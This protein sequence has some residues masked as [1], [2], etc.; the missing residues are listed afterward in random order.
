MFDKILVPLDG[1]TVAESAL[2]YARLLAEKSGCKVELLQVIDSADEDAWARAGKPIQNTGEEA[3]RLAERYLAE[4]AESF[5]GRRAE[6]RARPGSPAEVI[7]ETAAQ[8]PNTLIVLA[9]HGRTG[10]DRWLLGSVAEKV[11]RASSNPL[12]LV[13]ASK[14]N[15]ADEK[16][17]L[18]AILVPLDGSKLA[19]LALPPAVELARVLQAEV[20]LVGAYE[21]PS[22]AYYRSD[23]E[24]ATAA[25]F[26]PSYDDLVAA[27]S[28]ETRVYL[29]A[30]VQEL[31]SRTARV[32]SEIL[33]GP[34]AD[35]I[36]E[37]AHTTKGSLIAM[38]THG[39]S[40][41]RRW[42]LGSVTEKVARHADAPVLI[43]GAR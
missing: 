33:E 5:P 21:I 19:E 32:R 25:D 20:V 22:T 11:I 9:S 37:L 38:C 39:R 2:P 23:R 28:R 8:D 26:I 17:A 4:I 35:R 29:E 7:L 41:L 15:R 13:R 14:T 24:T 10:I 30:K 42:L 12:L 18:N 6:H 16:P 27:M 43:V 34:A 31:G 1:S 3:G 36:L 40:G